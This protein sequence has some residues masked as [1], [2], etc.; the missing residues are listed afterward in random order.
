MAR[1]LNKN[2]AAQGGNR[3]FYSL[4]AGGPVTQGSRLAN[5]RTRANAT[6]RFTRTMRSY[7]SIDDALNRIHEVADKVYARGGK[8][9]YAY[10]LAAEDF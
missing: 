1:A 5:L 8:R 7:K 3:Y 10:I 2:F 4:F 9:S 6:G